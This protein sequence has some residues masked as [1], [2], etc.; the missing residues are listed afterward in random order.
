MGES[1]CEWI[2]E[3]LRLTK[4]PSPKNVFKHQQLAHESDLDPPSGLLENL[5]DSLL[6]VFAK[7]RKPDPRF[8]EMRHHLDQFDEGLTSIER[9]AARNKL[10]LGDLAGDYEDL[11]A[12]VQGLGY[13]ESGITDSL[14]KFEVG[15]GHFSQV[16]SVTTA[17]T[18]DPFLEQLHS[19]L[20]YS[21]VFKGVLR[22][23]DQ[24]Q[25]DFEELSTYLSSEVTERDRLAGGYGSGMGI[26]SYFK[27]KVDSL[28]GGG[29][30][31]GSREARLAKLDGKIKEVS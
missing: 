16:I 27:D 2:W 17:H 5:S 14:N 31:D 25:F 18:T 26:G 11:A 29:Q 10:R 23:R 28:T 19:L 12:S 20:A 8:V 9:L 21:A 7:L 15:I 4:I 24:K 1:F 3:C 13:L 6:N 30:T 22:L